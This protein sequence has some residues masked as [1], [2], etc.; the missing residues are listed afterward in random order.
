MGKF[1]RILK[2]FTVGLSES[3]FLGPLGRYFSKVDREDL[4]RAVK[5]S[6]SF[7]RGELR[8]CI[9]SRLSVMDVLLNVTSEKKAIEMFSFLRV[10]DTEENS[11][12]LIYL[13]LSEKKIH[14]L[15]DRGI[16]KKIGQNRLDSIASK[17]G[18]GF[19]SGK[20]KEALLLGISELTVDL[21]RHFPAGKHNPNELPDEPYI[22]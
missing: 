22:K 7:H 15:A 16:Y 12:I 4:G 11:G 9:Q 10:W 3:V 2:N 14:I 19:R 8:I 17:I 1:N 20:P 5:K 18:E 13:L 6:E 21:S